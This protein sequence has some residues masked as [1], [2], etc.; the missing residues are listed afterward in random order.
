MQ[1]GFFAL[2][3]WETSAEKGGDFQ[4]VA[5]ALGVQFSFAD[6]AS[7]L[8]SVCNTEG[9]IKEVCSQIQ[10][11]LEKGK[12]SPAELATLRGR[13]VFAD[14]HI[15][16]RRSKQAMKVLSIACAKTGPV[17]FNQ[18]LVSALTCLR[19]RV[20]KGAP[21]LVHGTHRNKYLLF[22]DACHEK[23]GAGL[24]GI[25]YGPTGIVVAWYGEWLEPQELVCI[26]I[27]FKETLI[28]ELEASASHLACTL[29]CKGI[30]RSDII[31]FSDNEAVLSNFIT[32]K[33]DVNLVSRMLDEIYAWEGSSDCNLWFERV[34]SHAN[35]SDNPSRSV[36]DGLPVSCRKR[37]D[38][39][40]GWDKLLQT[41]ARGDCV[42]GQAPSLQMMP[43]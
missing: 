42:L 34:A 9:R 12:A 38:V 14:S 30:N 36:Y 39:K 24:G 20:L 13:L 19:D 7:G 2:L 41:S 31:C 27:D 5:K 32:G 18:D 17:S 11:F 4:A 26:N 37:V 35:P 28:Y 23:E 25:L 15:F 6:S 29:L 33:S 3:S 16:G 21:R 1:K 8:L 22:A 43:C 40:S 10:F